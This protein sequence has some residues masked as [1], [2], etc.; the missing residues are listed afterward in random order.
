MSTLPP[1]AS[2]PC[3]PSD[4]TDAEWALLDPLLP[5]PKRGGRPATYARREIVNAI[6]YLLRTGC[7]WRQLPHD[8]PPWPL[9]YHYF[10]QWRDDGTWEQVHT[11]L[12]ERLRLQLGR[13]ATPSAASLDS[14]SVKTTEKGG[15]AAM[16][17]PST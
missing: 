8:L 4:L 10:R 9:V 15:Y 6:Y 12:R 13:A 7:S 3:Y 1:G 17:A 16:T 5:A 11:R 2:R 14:Q